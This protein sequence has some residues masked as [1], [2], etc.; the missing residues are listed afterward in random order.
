LLLQLRILE[1]YYN[2]LA[3]RESILSRA[4]LENRAALL[5]VTSLPTDRE[6]EMIAPIGGGI[7]M[8]VTYKPDKKI[9]VAVGAGVAVEK[10]KDET[11]NFLD[12]RIKELERALEQVVKQREETVRRI[13]MIKNQLGQ[14]SQQKG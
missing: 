9:I 8:P 6:S 12:E 10:S 2:D 3:T 5:A 14:L 4:L 13:N 1:A 7:H 11:A